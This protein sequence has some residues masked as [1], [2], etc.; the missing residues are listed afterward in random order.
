MEIENL[1]ESF[2]SE[3][4]L[5]NIIRHTSATVWDNELVEK[6][7][8]SWLTNFKGEVFDLKYERLLALWL[9]C[10]F[11]YYNKE[12]VKHLCRVLYRDLIHLIVVRLFQ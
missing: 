6:D 8:E 4:E 3:E 2:P 12:E 5:L 11:T 1:F 9:L 10:H 7:I